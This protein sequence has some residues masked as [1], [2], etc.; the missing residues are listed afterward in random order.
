MKVE[1]K[2]SVEKHFQTN[3]LEIFNRWW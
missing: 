2:T 3:F 1:L